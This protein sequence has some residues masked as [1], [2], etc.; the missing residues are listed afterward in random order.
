MWRVRALA[1]GCGARTFS[2]CVRVADGD[3][4]RLTEVPEGVHRAHRGRRLDLQK[5]AQRSATRKADLQLASDAQRNWYHN[6]TLAA[7]PAPT[8]AQSPAVQ[9][10]S[11]P[12]PHE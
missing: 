6:P 10:H 12:H 8:P 3:V 1:R 7:P 5:W 2:G 11:A 9:M 4:R